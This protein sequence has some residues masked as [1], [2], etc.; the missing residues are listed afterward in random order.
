MTTLMLCGKDNF[1][2]LSTIIHRRGAIEPLGLPLMR[3]RRLS[4]LRSI[5]PTRRLRAPAP[6]A[7]KWKGDQPTTGNTLGN[8]LRLHAPITGA[9]ARLRGFF[10]NPR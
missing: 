8:L 10:G 4:G 1:G 6:T 7:K 2:H 9:I 5:L 3:S